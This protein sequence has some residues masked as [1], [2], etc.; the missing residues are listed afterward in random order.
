MFSFFKSKINSKG[1]KIDESR[2]YKKY[3][4]CRKFSYHI[5]LLIISDTHGL[6]AY[7]EEYQDKL[8]NIK[9]YDLCCALGDITYND[10]EIIL[11]Y[12][13]K[14]KIVALLGNHDEFDILKYYGLK[15]LNGNI[16]TVNGI[17]IGG[18]QGSYKYKPENFPS[19]THE[20]SIKFLNQMDE[21]DILLSH[22]GPYFD[23]NNTDLVHNGLKGITEYLYRNRVPY[24][25]HGHNH[26]NTDLYLRNGTKVIERY[27]IEEVHI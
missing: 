9:N 5:N 19:F 16:I 12:V 13:P 25:I 21:V 11:K 17:R 26:I 1:P 15:D 24:N 20:E 4:N 3:G 10:Y 2:L 22:T 18:I 6:L 27:F 7:N 8:I 14:E 23:N